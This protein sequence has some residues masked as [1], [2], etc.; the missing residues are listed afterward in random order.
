MPSGRLWAGLLA[1]VSVAVAAWQ[2]CAPV[3]DQ[4]KTAPGART[5]SGTYDPAFPPRVVATLPPDRAKN[6]DFA[7]QE[8]K[9]TFDRP[10]MTEKQWSWIIH[11]D[12][13]VY[14]GYEGSPDPR[15]EDGGRTCVLAV[16]LSPDTV[17]AVGANGVNYTGFRDTS[18]KV[19]VPYVWVFKTRTGQAPRER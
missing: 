15:W 10:M 7:L 5:N 9:V 6:V 1:A 13:G 19:A 17:Y 4:D 3:E 2:G 16:R 12:L 18:N 11:T 14:P 8:I